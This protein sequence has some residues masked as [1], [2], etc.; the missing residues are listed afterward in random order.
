MDASRSRE[1]LGFACVAAFVVVAALRDVYFA[2]T[3][4]AHSPLHVTVLAFTLGTLAFLPVALV[5]RQPL[6]ELRRW[7]WEVVGVNA[8]SAIAWIAY[9]YALKHLE[10]ALVQTLWAGVGP[11][12]IIW[13]EAAGVVLARPAPVGPAERWFHRGILVALVLATLV[14]ITGRSAGPGRPGLG[15]V[16]ALLS[17]IGISI[18]V[19][20]CKRL[21]ERQVG[22]ATILAVRFVG[23]VMVAATMAVAIGDTAL[24]GWS[25]G[26][27]GVVALAALLLIVAPIYI[28]Q[29]GIALAP[30]LTARA[31]IALG[32][33]LVFAL[34]LGEGRL[35]ASGSSLAVIVLYSLFAVLATVARQWPEWA[36]LR[37]MPAGG[38]S[39]RGTAGR[40]PEPGA[41]AAPASGRAGTSGAR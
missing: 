29:V 31:V 21:N 7:P 30:P 9:F 23:A 19:L 33:A 1:Q 32:P 36:P 34:Q 35:P 17:G 2:A 11:L 25:V 41:R 10:P 6:R 13:L 26:T 39:A 12:A 37:R 40:P 28:N 22:P 16:L 18:N 8:T 38:V 5:R 27:L 3:F 24:G 15:V 20:L 4:Q 14:A